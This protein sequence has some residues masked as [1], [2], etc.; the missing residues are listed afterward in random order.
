MASVE[1]QYPRYHL[2][3]LDSDLRLFDRARFL[4][5]FLSLCMDAY[6]TYHYL[7]SYPYCVISLPLLSNMGC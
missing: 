7:L 3:T 4:P 1:W 6:S 5:S 2:P